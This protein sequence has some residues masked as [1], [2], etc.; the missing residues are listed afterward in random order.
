MPS[1]AG[2]EGQEACSNMPVS[3]V[4]DLGRGGMRASHFNY[5]RESALEE[6]NLSNTRLKIELGFIM[7]A[8]EPRSL[9]S[10]RP[11]MMKGNLVSVK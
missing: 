4:P 1:R 5:A 7:A 3:R 6:G 9:L 8:G 2:S 11:A 10:G